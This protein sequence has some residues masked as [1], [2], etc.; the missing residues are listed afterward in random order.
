MNYYLKL[1]KPFVLSSALFGAFATSM[2]CVNPP[3]ITEPLQTFQGH[4]SSESISRIEAKDLGGIPIA[5][6]NEDGSLIAVVVDEKTFTIFD[7]NSGE[8]LHTENYL[9]E[10]KWI[11]WW[12]ESRI[13]VYS[14]REK[15]TFSFEKCEVNKLN[16]RPDR[17]SVV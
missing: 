14:Q 2:H 11:H 17:K 13:D 4:L 3:V 7:I 16:S 6:L 9:H 1:F 5:A 15:S 8:S 10:I 12:Y